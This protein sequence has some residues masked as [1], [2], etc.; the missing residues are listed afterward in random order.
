MLVVCWCVA[1]LG[2]VW[3][4]SVAACSHCVSHGL[5]ASHKY[6]YM[7]G[8]R[9]IAHVHSN[10]MHHMYRLW[11]MSRAIERRAADEPVAL[12]LGSCHLAKDA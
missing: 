11:G 2:V 1:E 8:K 5:E 9:C 7:Q 3:C 4:G 12:R 6:R 10:R